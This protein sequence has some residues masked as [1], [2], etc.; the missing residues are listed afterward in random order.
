MNEFEKRF[1]LLGIDVAQVLISQMDLK[2]KNTLN[3]FKNTL[4]FLHEQNVIPVIN[5]NDS[6]STTELRKNGHF[7]DNDF[8]SALI[9]KKTNADILIIITNTNGLIGKN[10]KIISE[11]KNED[12]LLQINEK[13]NNGTGGIKSKI[14]TIKYANKNKMDVFVSGGENFND[15]SIGKAKG[16][17]ISKENKFC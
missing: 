14:K 13:S 2:H 3:N 17:L 12:E 5:E 8:L 10:N 7:S 15:F 11:L 4:S 9:A 1:S 16:T 6:V